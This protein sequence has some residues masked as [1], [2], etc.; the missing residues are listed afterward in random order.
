[1]SN[2]PGYPFGSDWGSNGQYSGYTGGSP[3]SSNQGQTC[4]KSSPSQGGANTSAYPFPSNVSRGG[5]I[6]PGFDQQRTS[7]PGSD[8]GVAPRFPGCSQQR[9]Q[10]YTSRISD[11]DLQSRHSTT[12]SSTYASYGGGYV[13]PH[14]YVPPSPMPYGMPVATPQVPLR[15]H[16]AFADEAPVGQ[17]VLIPGGGG[18]VPPPPMSDILSNRSTGTS[19]DNNYPVG[20]LSL[21]PDRLIDIMRICPRC[22]RLIVVTD[23][24]NHTCRSK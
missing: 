5:W 18:R 3:H 6:R 20:R 1:M 16:V 8:S 10:S 4:Y 7:G 13:H 21:Q 22:S 19:S 17:G 15:T 11:S 23:E 9:N 12:P 24:R 14:G 2:S